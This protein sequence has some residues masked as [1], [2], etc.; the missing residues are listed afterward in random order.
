MDAY[1]R[2]TKSKNAS[3]LSEPLTLIIHRGANNRW[4]CAFQKLQEIS[5]HRKLEFV[6]VL[7]IYLKL[8]MVFGDGLHTI[9]GDRQK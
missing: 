1:N 8:F 3:R 5:V 2:V 4:K 9:R 7:S 6:Q